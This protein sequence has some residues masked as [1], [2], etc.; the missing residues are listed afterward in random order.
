LDNVQKGHCHY[1]PKSGI[2]VIAVTNTPNLF[3]VP[4]WMGLRLFCVLIG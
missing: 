1:G 2:T 3:F 4:R